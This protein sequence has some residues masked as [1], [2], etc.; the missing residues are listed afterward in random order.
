MLTKIKMKGLNIIRNLS[1]SK[2]YNCN[3]RKDIR[4]L[5]QFYKNLDIKN[6]DRNAFTLIGG[7]GPF[8]ELN[9]NLHSERF[10]K[11]YDKNIHT[12]A[13]KYNS[14]YLPRVK[15]KKVPQIPLHGISTNKS[16]NHRI[17][18]NSETLRPYKGLRFLEKINSR[19]NNN[20]P[21]QRQDIRRHIKRTFSSLNDSSMFAPYAKT[22]KSE[23]KDWKETPEESSLIRKSRRMPFD[24]QEIRGESNIILPVGRKVKVINMSGRT[25]GEK[26]KSVWIKIEDIPEEIDFIKIHSDMTDV[27]PSSMKESLKVPINSSNNAI[28]N[29]LIKKYKFK[30]PTTTLLAMKSEEQAQMKNSFP[31]RRISGTL[32]KNKAEILEKVLAFKETVKEF[33]E[34]REILERQIQLRAGRREQFL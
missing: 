34:S 14:T 2:R 33:R 28:E 11:G 31:Q 20:T 12:E 21:L 26:R 29:P 23:P 3:V 5:K 32:P 13:L 1:P 19:A 16:L 18:S 10:T 30:S 8:K 27:R 4:S 17:I 15:Y 22:V 7:R 24:L 25:K 9:R 6:P